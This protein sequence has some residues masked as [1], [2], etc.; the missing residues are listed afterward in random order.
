MCQKCVRNVSEMPSL[1][2]TQGC[3]RRI[4]Q[5]ELL[6][7]MSLMKATDRPSNYKNEEESFSW[8]TPNIIS[9]FFFFFRATMHGG[10][11]MVL[12]AYQPRYSRGL[13]LSHQRS[14]QCGQHGFC[15]T[16]F[17]SSSVR[18]THVLQ[19]TM[20]AARTSYK[21]KRLFGM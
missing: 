6:G 16:A 8:A 18:A 11:K 5:G 9:S 2:M 17:Q 7:M 19:F 4:R 14:C 15:L 20:S 12:Q 10:F 3:V 13:P 1:G 21:R